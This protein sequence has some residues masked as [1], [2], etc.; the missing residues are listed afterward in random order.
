MLYVLGIQ[1]VEGMSEMH[2]IIINLLSKQRLILG[3]SNGNSIDSEY[4]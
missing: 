3:E 4:R 2:H 1:F